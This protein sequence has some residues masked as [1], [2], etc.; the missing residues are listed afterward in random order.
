MK[1]KTA[2]GSI[3]KIA[4]QAQGDA[5]EGEFPPRDILRVEDGNFQAFL[6]G[7]VIWANQSAAIKK[8]DLIDVGDVDYGERSVDQYR[9]TRFFKSFPVCALGCGFAIFHKAG[10]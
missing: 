8:M 10:R 2:V 1:A 7:T 6:A 5:P 9:C 4:L 3:R